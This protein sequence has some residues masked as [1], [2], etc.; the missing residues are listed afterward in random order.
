MN[1]FTERTKFTVQVLLHSNN[2]EFIFSFENLSYKT[3]QLIFSF[4]EIKWFN[5][6]D[7]SI[8][9]CIKCSEK[10]G[11]KSFA[12]NPEAIGKSLKKTVKDSELFRA[13]ARC[14]SSKGLQ[15]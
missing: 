11:K 14:I 2:S 9:E 13:S 10:D 6:T 3:A 4:N 1:K 7:I 5:E 8:R 15:S 12:N